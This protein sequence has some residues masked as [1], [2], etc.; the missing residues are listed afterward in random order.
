MPMLEGTI[1]INPVTAVVTGSGAAKEIFDV[2]NDG[3]DYQ[4]ITGPEL[5][6]A[7]EQLALLARAVAKIIPHITS[8]ALVTVAAGITLTTTAPATGSTNSTYRQPVNNNT[9]LS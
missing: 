1:V 7:K 3:T 6:V 9:V 8:N 2:M 5:A 4:G